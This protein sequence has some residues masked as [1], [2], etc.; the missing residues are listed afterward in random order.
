MPSIAW[1]VWCSAGFGADLRH[2]APD[3]SHDPYALF[4]SHLD[5][6]TAA[7]KMAVHAP[8]VHLG[9]VMILTASA[10]Q[11]DRLLDIG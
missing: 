5:G 11:Q 10:D 4:P 7:G 8:E 9:P 3:P 1:P 2:P 6:G